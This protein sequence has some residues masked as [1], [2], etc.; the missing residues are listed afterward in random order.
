[1]EEDC[2]LSEYYWVRQSSKSWGYPTDYYVDSFNIITNSFDSTSTFGDCSLWGYLAHSI[3]NDTLRLFT[4]T[5][6][7]LPLRFIRHR[8]A[9][10]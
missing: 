2:K 3:M 10:D 5:S 4:N 9:G 6:W 8:E 1:L 7:G